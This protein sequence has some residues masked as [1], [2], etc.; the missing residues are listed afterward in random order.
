MQFQKKVE[1]WCLVL[2]DGEARLHLEERLL[3][4]LLQA[5]SGAATNPDSMIWA[6][7]IIWCV[8]SWKMMKS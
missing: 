8:M 5:R 1:D 7:Q 3:G 4:V 2:E 6:A